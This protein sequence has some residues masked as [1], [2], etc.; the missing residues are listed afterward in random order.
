M[1]LLAW[2][3]LAN[4]TL[5]I[6]HEIDSAYRQEWKL[7]RLPGGING[8]LIIHIPLVLLILWGLVELV[9]GT[10]TG[11]VLSIVLALAGIFAFCIHLYLIWKGHGEFKTPVSLILLA[12]ILCVSIAQLVVTLVGLFSGCGCP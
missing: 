10:T 3:Y 8:F 9:A 2:L 4:A 12:G 5:L 6:V 11:S 7:F 1:E